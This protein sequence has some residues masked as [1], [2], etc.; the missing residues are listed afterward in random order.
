MIRISTIIISL[1]LLI[2]TVVQ[3]SAIEIKGVQIRASEGR[4]GSIISKPV[5]LTKAATI[6]RIDGPK[7]GF[8]ITGTATICSSSEIIGM[9]LEPGTYSVFPNVPEGKNKEKVVIYLR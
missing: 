9:T 1:T 5:V 4:S 2:T 6:I 3:T 8:C 7:E